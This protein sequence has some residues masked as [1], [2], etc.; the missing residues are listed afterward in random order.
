MAMKLSFTKSIEY[1][2]VII[3]KKLFVAVI[4]ILLLVVSVSS[5]FAATDKDVFANNGMVS[6]AHEL[7]SKAG[8]E[9]LQKGGNAVDAAVATSLALSVVEGHFTGIGGGGFMTIR[10]AETG[11][12]T[13][14]DYREMAP[15]ASTKEMFAGDKKVFYP[16]NVDAETWKTSGGKTVGVPGWVAG[17]FY[18]LEEYGT[19]SFAEVAKP[20]I[21]MA[22]LGW[23]VEA[24]QSYWYEYMSLPL[25]DL[26]E[27]KDIPFFNDGFPYQA[28]E[29]ITRMDLAKTY[30]ILA[31]KGPKAFYQGEIGEAFVKEVQRLGGIMTMDDLKNY[32]LYERRP[33]T[34]KYHGYQIY[35]AP[36]A[37]SGGTHIVQV[38]N[39]LENF[40]MKDWAPESP[41]RQ[42][43]TAEAVRLMFA[44]RQKYMAD[45]DFTNVPLKGLVDKDY[46]KKIAQKI[47]IHK[48]MESVQAGDPWEFEDKKVAKYFGGQLGLGSSTSHFSVADAAGNIVACT[49]THN[50]AAGF[51][52][53][54]GIVLNNEM[55][56]FSSDPE[57]VNA[58]EP[59]KRPL[60]SM[61]PTIILTPNGDPF[62]TVGSAGGWRILTA[63]IQIIT[64]VIDYDMSMAEA[65]NYPRFFTYAI[66]GEPAAYIVEDKMPETTL[67]GLKSYG[68]KIDVRKSGDYFGTAQGIIYLEDKMNGGADNR[69]LGVPVGY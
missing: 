67:E 9:I 30:E 52:P 54:Y 59:G 25:V 61:S 32:K 66:G 56:D 14:L 44:D 1:V 63:L 48:T 18:A 24:N 33:T 45:S 39:I 62:M 6:S 47:N 37:S 31:E 28:N 23:E 10:D 65:I 51:V 40:P 8:V 7:A 35:S 55:A 60:S 36:P 43:V 53:E 46:A 68:E 12:V 19:M 5:V 49:N 11:D 27:L 34:G 42:H 50:Y 4:F 3:V 41:E 29:Y 15:T 69:R 38:L 2:G 57:S 58:P 16:S 20:A 21:R 26:Y 64:N 17:M 22:I 13:F